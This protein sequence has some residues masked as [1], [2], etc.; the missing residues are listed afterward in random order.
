MSTS[1]TSV[2]P[3]LTT[4]ASPGAL[5]AARRARR[6]AAP[7]LGAGV[8]GGMLLAMLMMVVMGITGM[9]FLSAINVG[10]PAFVYTITPPLAMF[11]ALLAVMG[12]TLPATAM[13]QLGAAISSGHVS[14]A[15]MAKFASLL[16]TMHVPMS[17]IHL[18]GLLMSGHATNQTVAS[19]MAAMTPAA[20]ASV[21]AAMP[22]VASHLVV[23]LMLH[24]AFAA[25]LGLAFFGVLG[26]LARLGAPFAGPAAAIA[27]GTVGGAIVYFVM[28]L[29]VLPS[30]NPLMAFVPQA[31][32]FVAHLVF[33]AT[34]GLAFAL[35]T[36]RRGRLTSQA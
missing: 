35:V 36:R 20:R 11:P 26:A 29:G 10:M 25:V 15:M 6:L 5:T 27:W 34:V 1:A 23:G 2:A 31:A 24:L 22:T 32:F 30:T 17:K 4:N 9:G 19:L 33:G 3:V 14:S 13:A 12:I 21:I 28:R 8:G 7:A 18:I 16:A